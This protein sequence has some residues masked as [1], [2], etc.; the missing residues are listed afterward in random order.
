MSQTSASRPAGA[1]GH[2]VPPDFPA[3]LRAAAATSRA[4]AVAEG[5]GL[6]GS[7][8]ALVLLALWELVARNLRMHGFPGFPAAPDWSENVL[9]HSVFLIG[10]MGGMYAT[11]TVRH[12]R[13]DAI[14]RLAGVRRRLMLR[15]VATA[16]AIT[17]CAILVWA[18]WEYR[19]H[20]LDEP[21]MQGDIFTP[22]RSAMMIV[23]GLCGIIW[24]F[25]VQLLIDVTYLAGKREVPAFWVAEAGHGGEAELVAEDL[26]APPPAGAG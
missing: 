2:Y 17:V 20:V 5:V 3:P 18:A 9:R 13:V 10:F 14:T 16:G 6:A 7:L 22:A 26:T 23:L 8:A 4:L 24:H 12:L 19:G 11:Y 15:V 25:L 21:V 1:P